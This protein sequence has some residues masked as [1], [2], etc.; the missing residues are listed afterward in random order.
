MYFVQNHF[1]IRLEKFRTYQV[2]MCYF[3]MYILEQMSEKN[4][5]LNCQNDKMPRY[6]QSTL[7]HIKCQND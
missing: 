3:Q 4:K 7:N 5:N 6:S 2:F 1:K